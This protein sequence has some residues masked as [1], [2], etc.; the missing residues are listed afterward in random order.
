MPKQYE[1]G[2]NKVVFLFCGGVLFLKPLFLMIE[3]ET[4]SVLEITV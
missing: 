2:K 1:I 4:K 3:W